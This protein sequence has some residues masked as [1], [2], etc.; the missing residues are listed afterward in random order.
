[1]ARAA[2]GRAGQRFPK[3]ARARN[4]RH[5][6]FR[7]S[8]RCRDGV[9]AVAHRRH[10]SLASRPFQTATIS[11]VRCCPA[12]G[13]ECLNE[14]PHAM[15]GQFAWPEI[16]SPGLNG[17]FRF[18]AVRRLTAAKE[19]WLGR[20]IAWQRYISL[21][22]SE[23]WRAPISRTTAGICNGY[24][25]PNLSTTCATRGAATSRCKSLDQANA[26][27]AVTL[28]A[29]LSRRWTPFQ[30]PSARFRFA[31]TQTTFPTKPIFCSIVDSGL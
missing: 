7:A 10:R 18:E 13:R 30:C 31:K 15:Q 27:A 3:R 8:I 14:P 4:C 1:M 22:E 9:E 5:A 23:P 21:L 17:V 20:E 28:C 24:S 2:C 26:T 16:R 12:A 29:R 6:M 11:R 19:V 25:W